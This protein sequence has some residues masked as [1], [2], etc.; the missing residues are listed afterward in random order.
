[1]TTIYLLAGSGTQRFYLPHEDNDLFWEQVRIFVQTDFEGNAP[2][3]AKIKNWAKNRDNGMSAYVRLL[4]HLLTGEKFRNNVM[5]S[6]KTLSDVK[7]AIIDKEND[8][9]I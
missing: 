7:K 4:Q 1:M 5:D 6:R 2:T 3:A 9:L 8:D